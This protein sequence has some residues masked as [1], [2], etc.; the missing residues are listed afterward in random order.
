[1][2][3]PNKTILA[4]T[5]S[6]LAFSAGVAIGE[7]SLTPEPSAVT[8]SEKPAVQQLTIYAAV[9]DIPLFTGADTDPT[10]IEQVQS[11]LAGTL[12]K[13]GNGTADNPE[14]VEFMVKNGFKVVVMPRV[15]DLDNLDSILYPEQKTAFVTTQG[16][17]I[18]S[19]LSEILRLVAEARIAQLNELALA[20]DTSPAVA[21]LD[22][23]KQAIE[24]MQKKGF[25]FYG[26]EQNYTDYIVA[27]EMVLA[28]QFKPYFERLTGVI[29]TGLEKAAEAGGQSQ[30][31]IAALQPE[32]ELFKVWSQ[33][34]PESFREDAA[35][36][37]AW[38]E[39]NG[40][41]SPLQQLS[42]KPV[43]LD[44]ETINHFRAGLP[45]SPVDNGTL[46]EENQDSAET[47]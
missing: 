17:H 34:T 9:F 39:R 25:V 30:D 38:V 15:Q 35:L 18:D 3:F 7:E 20:D 4:T 28:N 33:A 36:M 1:M 11:T 21:E 41:S 16:I 6:F 14:L 2:Q 27:S 46:K 47:L 24:A 26:D 32:L 8:A 10:L 37:C 23:L 19:Y 13:N 29:H 12:D 43:V 44:D 22:N 40:L 45:V 5:L 42:D 31:N